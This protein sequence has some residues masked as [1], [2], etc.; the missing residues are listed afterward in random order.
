MKDLPSMSELVKRLGLPTAVVYVQLYDLYRKQRRQQ[1]HYHAGRYWVRMPYKDFPRMFPDLPEAIVS[2]ALGNLEDE[3]LLRMVHCG[4]LS[5]YVIDRKASACRPKERDT[6]KTYAI[7]S[8]HRL[9][10]SK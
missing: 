4:R 8:A 1:G 7:S 9:D 2:E 3:G 5:W 6:L 10:G